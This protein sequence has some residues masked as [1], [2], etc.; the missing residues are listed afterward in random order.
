VHVYHQ[1][2]H[3]VEDE[4]E[5]VQEPDG[6]RTGVGTPVERIILGIAEEVEADGDHCH[7]GQDCVLEQAAEEHSAVELGKREPARALGGCTL[8]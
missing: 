8:W 3:L 6:V 2:C 5:H 1:R 4:V 7:E